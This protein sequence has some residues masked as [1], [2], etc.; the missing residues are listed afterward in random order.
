ML[1]QSGQ[2]LGSLSLLLNMVNM[3]ARGGTRGSGHSHGD[4]QPAAH[5]DA[6]ADGRCA[7]DPIAHAYAAADGDTNPAAPAAA[8]HRRDSFSGGAGRR[9]GPG[10]SVDHRCLPHSPGRA[11]GG[12]AGPVVGSALGGLLAY[13]LSAGADPAATWLTGA[14]PGAG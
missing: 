7:R 5:R 10:C 12:G 11:R 1:V 2:A 8:P 4:T 13:L 3:R 6:D 9:L 14:G